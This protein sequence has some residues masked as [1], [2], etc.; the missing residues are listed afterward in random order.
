MN[1]KKIR[2][3]LKK[4][5][6]YIAVGVVSVGAVAAIF[7][8]P[9]RQGNVKEQP[10]PYAKNEATVGRGVDGITKD[11]GDVVVEYNDTA[12]NKTSGS[13]IKSKDT[14]SAEDKTIA[15]HAKV[16][17]KDNTSKNQVVA[18]TFDSTTA[19]SKQAAFF[20]EG[21]TFNW[22]VQGE[23]VVPY[24]D[25]S[26]T[27]WFSD[28]LNQTMRTFGICISAKE[29]QAVKAVADGKV[30]DIVDDSS[31]LKSDMPYVAKTM[32][33]DHG[34]GYITRY[35][36]QNG[37]PN[38]GLLG[39]AV[40]AGDVLGKAG[41]PTGAF[42]KQ[43]DNIYLQAL[44]NKKVINPLELLDYKQASAHIETETVDMGHTPDP[45]E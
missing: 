38:K 21:D 27:Y 25:E 3:F 10:N 32:I 39:K 2:Q 34:N 20:A 19:D 41:K 24:T 16:D 17:K 30:I 9:N 14:A 31:T 26:T 40:K 12:N 42:I 29:G 43:G 22:P 33:V 45:V 15:D 6:F 1:I 18:E 4:Y 28:S 23:V 13:S 7:L 11:T 8:V 36:F 37:V 44:H 35:G 5:A